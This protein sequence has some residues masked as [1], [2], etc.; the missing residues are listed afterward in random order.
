MAE[1]DNLIKQKEKV[2]KSPSLKVATCQICKSDNDIY[3]C[4]NGHK[5]LFCKKCLSKSVRNYNRNGEILLKFKAKCDKQGKCNYQPLVR[6]GGIASIPFEHEGELLQSEKDFKGFMKI[7]KYIRENEIELTNEEVFE[8]AKEWI[9]AISYS[10]I[11][12][13]QNKL[14]EIH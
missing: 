13:P 11:N 8:R 7:V 12:L 1:F 5:V 2:L 9:Q 6:G 10:R 4:E 3:V 14:D